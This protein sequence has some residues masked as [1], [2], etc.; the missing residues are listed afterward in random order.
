MFRAEVGTLQSL[1]RSRPR[2]PVPIPPGGRH[3]VKRPDRNPPSTR[4]VTVALGQ[5][6]DATLPEPGRNAVTRRPPS[7]HDPGRRRTGWR[8]EVPGLTGDARRADGA[9]GQAAQGAAGRRRAGLPN[10]SLSNVRSK[11]SVCWWPTAEPVAGR[12]GRVGR[13]GVP[14][15]RSEHLLISAGM[16]SRRTSGPRIDGRAIGALKDLRVEAMLVVG[17]VPAWETLAEVLGDA[18]V[19]VAAGGAGVPGPT[20]SATTTTWGCAWWSTTWWP[21]GTRP[22]RTWAG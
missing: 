13:S 6:Q 12:R 10:C 21:V 19:V 14:G 7:T 5:V 3:E 16:P 4:S 11:P 18:P 2:R 9:S 22:S 15:R 20:W 17:S 8:V 1:D